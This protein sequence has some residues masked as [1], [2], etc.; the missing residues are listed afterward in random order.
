MTGRELIHLLDQQR[1]DNH[2]FIKWWRNDDESVAIELLD[3]FLD[4]AKV[5]DRFD[6]FKLL[7]MEDLWVI[8]KQNWSRK[9][10]RTV[11][12]KNE[13]I[14]WEEADAEGAIRHVS[15]KFVPEVLIKVY[16]EESKGTNTEHSR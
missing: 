13:V 8:V 10:A 12:D 14:L 11:Q 9:I 5:G 7:D 4:T 6:G 2:C 15:G 16:A 1:S 3:T